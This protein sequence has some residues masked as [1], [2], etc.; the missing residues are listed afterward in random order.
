MSCE[1]NFHYLGDIDPNAASGVIPYG[2]AVWCAVCGALEIRRYGVTDGVTDDVYIVKTLKPS[3]DSKMK[4]I[5]EVI[6]GGTD[7][8]DSYVI[9]FFSNEKSA[10]EASIG[11][12]GMG[13]GDGT[14][15]KY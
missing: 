3:G 13:Y 1:H 14:I 7:G 12:G 15:R 2:F 4:E 8:R 11:Q 10:K 5:F 9:G 6:N